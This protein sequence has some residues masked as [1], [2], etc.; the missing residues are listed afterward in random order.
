MIFRMI[1]LSLALSTQLANASEL[2]SQE[3]CLDQAAS[4]YQARNEDARIKL[5]AS[6]DLCDSPANNGIEDRCYLFASRRY[7]TA[8]AQA[9]AIFQADQS[10]CLR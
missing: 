3:D 5:R 2:G 9:K 8:L 7:E 10:Q 1:L 4:A 6:M